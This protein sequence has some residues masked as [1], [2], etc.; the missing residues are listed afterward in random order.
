M[1]RP[2]SSLLLLLLLLAVAPGARGDGGGGTEQR[3]R[4]L[5]VRHHYQPRRQLNDQ[6]RDR[7]D[8]QRA[9]HE[10]AIVVSQGTRQGGG[11]PIDI[12]SADR[13]LHL[14]QQDDERLPPSFLLM[15]GFSPFFDPVQVGWDNACRELTKGASRCYSFKPSV[16]C[17]ADQEQFLWRILDGP[18]AGASFH[19]DGTP[20]S[21]LTSEDVA[22]ANFFRQN[23]V[24]RLAGIAMVA[25]DPQR[26]TPVINRIKLERNVSVVTFD[27]DAPD[28]LRSAHVGTD[29]RFLGVTLANVLR[30][31]RPEGGTYGIVGGGNETNIVDRIGAFREE[32]ERYNGEAGKAHWLEV[33]GSPIPKDIGSEI[34]LA[35]P[36]ADQNV[37]AIITMYQVTNV[38]R[39]PRQHWQ[40]HIDVVDVS[41]DL[42]AKL[43]SNPFATYSSPLLHFFVYRRPRC[44]RR[45]GRILWMLTD[46][47]TSYMLVRMRRITRSI[48]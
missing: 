28:S 2:T 37:T 19:D 21:N 33:E 47:R 9:G 38:F 6:E 15:N 31:L 14:P 43:S 22:M 30:Q 25:C 17:S 45:I 46:S 10:A 26:L 8:E 27:T 39:L 7:D 23:D 13:H 20:P 32:I 29:N 11:D 48:I 35:Q 24:S 5:H 44:G 41:V 34:F 1:A 3:R 16:Y 40:K 18:D 4:R 36:L 12:A 42:T